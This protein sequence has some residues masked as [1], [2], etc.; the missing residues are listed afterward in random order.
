MTQ[1][2]APP[3]IAVII[4]NYQMADVIIEHFRALVDELE[5]FPGSTVYIVDNAS[6]NGDAEKLE[7]FAQNYMELVRVIVSPLNGGFAKGNNLALVPALAAPAPPDFIFLLN[8]DA[9]VRKG[10]LSALVDFVSAHPRAGIAGSRLE[11][12][13]GAAQASAFRFLTPAS[14]F[15][16]C[17]RT[18]AISALLRPWSV[19]PAQTDEIR[20]A[21]WV[22]G[23]SVLIRREV[24]EAAGLFDEAYFLYY[25]ETDFM[26][27]AVRH[28][29]EI[30][31]VPTSRVVHLVGRSTGVVD[32]KRKNSAPPD[33]WFASRRRYFRKNH[34]RIFAMLADAAW[35]GGSA[36]F[37]ARTLISGRWNESPWPAIRSFLRVN[38]REARAR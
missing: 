29:F 12:P 10:A 1:E 25:E 23:A 35:L 3:R 21:D 18:G 15:E 38:A 2:P 28:G 20:R 13:D 14:E 11:F 9:Y 37:L 36:L 17:A 34:G 27:Q 5:P 33:Y 24:F 19:A 8:P 7:R 26:L 16:S 31:Y 30:W 6:P 22:C 4:V 32:G